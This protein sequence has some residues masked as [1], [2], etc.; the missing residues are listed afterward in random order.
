[1]VIS[2]VKRR[3]WGKIPLPVSFRRPRILLEFKHDCTQVHVERNK[4]LTFEFSA[5]SNI[6]QSSKKIFLVFLFHVR[7]ILF[8]FQGGASHENRIDRSSYSGELNA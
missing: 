4:C 6:I 7:C 5:C 2:R 3:T 1:M 8:S